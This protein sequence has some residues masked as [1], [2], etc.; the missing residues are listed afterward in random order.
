MIYASCEPS[1]TY[2]VVVVWRV[3]TKYEVT[4]AAKSNEVLTEYEVKV[5]VLY[6][7]D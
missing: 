5:A 4:P 6:A 7:D 1:R 2:G 3:E